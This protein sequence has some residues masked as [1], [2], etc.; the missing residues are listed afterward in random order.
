MAASGTD[1]KW[2]V[3]TIGADPVFQ[4]SLCTAWT[5]PTFTNAWVNFGGSTQIARYRKVGDVVEIEGL[6]KTGTIGL[7]AFTLPA[8]FRPTLTEQFPQVS[9][10]LFGALN[11]LSDGTVVPLVGNNASFS[12]SCRFSTL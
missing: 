5:A 7:S 2:T 10:S 9:N 1:K 4:A 12:L 11:V 6:I 8:G 3:A